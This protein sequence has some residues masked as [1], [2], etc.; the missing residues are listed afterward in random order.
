M[1]EDKSMLFSTFGDVLSANKKEVGKR[2]LDNCIT[3]PIET[4]FWLF[5]I[6]FNWIKCRVKHV[7]YNS[8]HY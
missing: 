2:S 6:R 4:L 5:K 3:I 1:E 7:I 8:S